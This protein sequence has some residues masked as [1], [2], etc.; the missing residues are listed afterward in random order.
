MTSSLVCLDQREDDGEA[1]GESGGVAG[2][3]VS[4]GQ[5]LNEML[6]AQVGRSRKPRWMMGGGEADG[7]VHDGVTQKKTCLPALRMVLTQPSVS[8]SGKNSPGESSWE[9]RTASWG[10]SLSTT[11]FHDHHLA[12]DQLLPVPCKGSKVK[13]SLSRV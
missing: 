5:E 11:L 7:N 3:A 6:D 13:K 2:S 1:V 10:P 9:D 8:L 12:L 4:G